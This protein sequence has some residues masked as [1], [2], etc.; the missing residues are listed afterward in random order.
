M[1]SKA[2]R[3]IADLEAKIEEIE[4][5]RVQTRARINQEWDHLSRLDSGK[6]S[7]NAHVDTIKRRKFRLDVLQFIRENPGCTRAELVEGVEGVETSLTKLS[8]AFRVLRKA[9]LIEREATSGRKYALWFPV[10]ENMGVW[11]W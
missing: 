3:W 9:N 6:M 4:N 10:M 7:L 2:D 11:T 8:E 5:N 1:K